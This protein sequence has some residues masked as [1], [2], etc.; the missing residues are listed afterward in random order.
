MA[1]LVNGSAGIGADTQATL[2]NKTLVSPIIQDPTIT[3]TTTN[4]NT[5]NLVVEDKNIVIND[6][7][8][9]SDANA[10]GGGISLSGGTT[11]TLNW[12]NA[13]SAWTSSEDFNLLTGKVFEINGTAVL[14]STE[15]LGKA[16]PSGTI[17]GTT[18]TQTLTNKTLASPVFTGQVTGLELAFSQS[19]VFEGTTADAFETTLSAGDPTAD[20]VLTLPNVTGTLAV[21]DDLSNL[22]ITVIMSAF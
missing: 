6:V 21:Q 20:R 13:T 11:K 12:V 5:A 9:P 16:V 4:I 19:I 15:V 8:S 22:E 3:G 17:I 10:D 18:D 2:T 1:V 14:S 7:V